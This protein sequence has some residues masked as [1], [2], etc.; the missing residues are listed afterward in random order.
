MKSLP[1]G[2]E[3]I[4]TRPWNDPPPRKRKT[5]EQPAPADPLDGDDSDSSDSNSASPSAQDS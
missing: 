4:I 5:P 3:S 2:I 1:I